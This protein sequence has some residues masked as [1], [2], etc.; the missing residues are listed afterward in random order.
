[1]QGTRVRALVREDPTCCGA[2]KPMCHNYWACAL[3]PV[4]L[5]YWACVLQLL[6]PARLEPVLCN[7]R[8]HRTATKSSP[9]SSQLEKARA[10]QQRPNAAKKK[11]HNRWFLDL[12]THDLI[13]QTARRGVLEEYWT[14]HHNLENVLLSIFLRFGTRIECFLLIW[15]HW[16]TWYTLIPGYLVEIRV[17]VFWL[18]PGR[19]FTN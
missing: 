9:R 16:S 15:V 5:N 10:Q 2:A 14:N 8:S 19:H 13:C 17:K 11:K 18:S 6:K 4:S 7:K 12:W 3:E 1:M